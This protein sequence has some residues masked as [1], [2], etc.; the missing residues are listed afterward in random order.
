MPPTGS[1]SGT[2]SFLINI[3]QETQNFEEISEDEIKKIIN[4]L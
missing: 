4:D 3:W 2:K 1:L